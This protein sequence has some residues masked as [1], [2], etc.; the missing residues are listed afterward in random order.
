MFWMVERIANGG[1]FFL[2]HRAD[3]NVYTLEFLLS[4]PLVKKG[5]S[6]KAL[7]GNGDLGGSGEDVEMGEEGEWQGIGEDSD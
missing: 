3:E 7:V 1:F 6:K 5:V 2:S 4:A